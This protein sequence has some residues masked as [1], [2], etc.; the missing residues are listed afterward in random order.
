MSKELNS[1]LLLKLSSLVKRGSTILFLLRRSWTKLSLAVCY[2]KLMVAKSSSDV[3]SQ[4]MSKTICH[5]WWNWKEVY[6]IGTN[7]ILSELPCLEFFVPWWF[8]RPCLDV[9]Q[10]S[11]Q[12]ASAVAWMTQ[13]TS[14]QEP[15]SSSLQGFYPAQCTRNGIDKPHQSD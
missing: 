6:E 1:S 13:K 12:I 5:P 2:C 15:N 7:F 10:I 11:F 4:F 3:W 8:P 14:W 9:S